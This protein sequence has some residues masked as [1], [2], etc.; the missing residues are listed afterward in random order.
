[1]E[2]T[3]E[4]IQTEAEYDRAL[5]EVETLMDATPG[6]PQGTRFDVL[7]RMIEAYEAKHWDVGDPDPPPP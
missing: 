3:P 1:M 5:A 4:S 7:V 6:T 2:R